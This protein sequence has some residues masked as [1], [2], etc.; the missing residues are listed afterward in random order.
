MK[1]PYKVLGVSSNATDEEIKKAYRE[2][3]RK[4]HPDKYRD[5]DLA[6]LAGEKMKEINAAYEEIQKERSGRGGGNA[7]NGTYGG[8]RAGKA[9]FVNLFKSESGYKL[10]ISPIEMLDAPERAFEFKVR[11]WFRPALPVPQFLEEVSRAG[12][13]HHSAIIYDATVEQLAFFAEL[14]G[15]PTV[16][17]K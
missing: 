10:F 6:D 17:V 11:G 8:Y 2:L 15:L 12:A 13:T 3:V 9:T 5:S 1:D 4:Y 14:L 7:Q 16:I